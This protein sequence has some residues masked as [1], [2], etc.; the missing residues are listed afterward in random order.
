MSNYIKVVIWLLRFGEEWDRLQGIYQYKI[1]M[2]PFKTKRNTNAFLVHIAYMTLQS[3]GKHQLKHLYI[4][5]N[6]VEK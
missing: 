1:K 3:T 2:Y 6:N 5:L 4:K